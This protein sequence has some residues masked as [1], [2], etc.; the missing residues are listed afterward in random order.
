MSDAWIRGLTMSAMVL[1]VLHAVG[2]W[3]YSVLGL[4]A[5]IASAALVAAV[6]VL[7]ARMAALG[8]GNHAWFVVPTV[9]FTTLPLVA[10]LFSVLTAEH[11]WW[12]GIVELA[13]FL[14]GF[15][16]PVLL[17]LTVYLEL[18]RRARRSAP[19]Q[20]VPVLLRQRGALRG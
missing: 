2:S 19:G 8:D 13:P 6:S 11:G 7:S 1:L 18:G 5:A 15:A 20:A 9:L 4:T 17:L 12:A 10:K 14:L 16:A 3:V